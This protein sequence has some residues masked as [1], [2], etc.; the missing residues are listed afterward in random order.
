MEE[1]L[2]RIGHLFAGQANPTGEQYAVQKVRVA[3]YVP[4]QAH[5]THWS[6]LKRSRLKQ[7]VPIG[8]THHAGDHAAVSPPA[9]RL[10]SCRREPTCSTPALMPP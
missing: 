3:A 5:G 10:R 6:R 2:A 1:V 4:Q 7:H 8:C 9:A